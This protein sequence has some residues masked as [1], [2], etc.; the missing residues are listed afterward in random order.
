MGLLVL[1]MFVVLLVVV[2]DFV[3]CVAVVELV[4]GLGDSWELRQRLFRLQEDFLD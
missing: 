1:L 3:L 4:V 2:C